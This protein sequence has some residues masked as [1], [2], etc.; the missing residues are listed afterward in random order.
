MSSQSEDF[1]T[2][3]DIP[4]LGSVVHASSRHDH[5]VGVE[6][7]ANNLHLVSFESLQTLTCLRI[8]DLRPL[9]EATS[10]NFIATKFL[11]TQFALTRKDY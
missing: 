10:H 8:P 2:R 11:D 5:A 6:R 7:Q 4:Q 1:L 9:V 3:L